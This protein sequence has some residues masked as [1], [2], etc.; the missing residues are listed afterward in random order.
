MSMV[1]TASTTTSD[2][3]VKVKMLEC[4]SAKLNCWVERELGEAIM[5]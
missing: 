4:D 3:E 5:I 1:Q 2:I